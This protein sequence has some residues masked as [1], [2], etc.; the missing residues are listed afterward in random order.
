M[1][2]KNSLIST[3][4]NQVS[5]KGESS[6]LNTLSTFNQTLAQKFLICQTTQWHVKSFKL[7]YNDRPSGPGADR[8]TP[9]QDT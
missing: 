4:F 7:L 2:K 1:I 3:N 5:Q 6:T 8:S 9:L